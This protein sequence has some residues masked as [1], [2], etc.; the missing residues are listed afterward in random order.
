MRM[1]DAEFFVTHIVD[2]IEQTHAW[3]NNL[4]AAAQVIEVKLTPKTEKFSIEYNDRNWT[5]AE[6]DVDVNVFVEL[7]RFAG[8]KVEEP[9]GDDKKG[10][11]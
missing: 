3:S 2:G 11:T 4:R 9:V 7:L 5:Y 6:F 8:Y 1:N 10:M